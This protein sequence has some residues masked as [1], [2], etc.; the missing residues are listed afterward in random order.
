MPANLVNV[1]R[2]TVS[3]GGSPLL[4][5]ISLG[6]SEG[7]RIGVVGRNG[8]GKTTLLRVLTGAGQ[9]DGG[10]VT[11]ARGLEEMARSS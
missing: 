6:V 9:P 1:E 4:D 11:R 2:V 5:R 7:D 10:R 3:Y 8:S